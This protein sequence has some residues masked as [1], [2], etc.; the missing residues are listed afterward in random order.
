MSSGHNPFIINSKNPEHSRVVKRNSSEKRFRSLGFL[1]IMIS[2]SF[3]GFLLFT[4]FSKGITG[5]ITTKIQLELPI[6]AEIDKYEGD[7]IEEIYAKLNYRKIVNQALMKIFP[8]AQTRREKFDLYSMLSRTAYIQAE[9]LV[10][11]DYK[12]SGIIRNV[13][14][15]LTAASEVDMLNKGK[16]RTDVPENKRNISDNQI[17]YVK[18]LEKI[19]A[20]ES[21]F[22]KAFFTKGDSREAESAGILGSITGSL[23]VIFICM[24]AALP[25]GIA[26][27]IYLE[28]FAPASRLKTV[29][30][31]AINNLAAIPSIVYG[32]LGLAVFLNWFGMP[33]SSAMAG[34]LTLGL[35]VLPVIII[36]TRNALAAVPPSIRDAARGLGAS[37]MQ[38][39]FHHVLPLSMPGIMTGS[40]L[41]L[42]RALGETA[43]LLMIGMVAFIKDVPQDVM[44]PATALPVQ[45]YI[46]S[47]LPEMG[48]AEKTSAAIIVL[49]LFLVAANA[50]AVFL[51]KKFEYKW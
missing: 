15:W 18:K 7:N 25:L 51:R 3:L 35:L 37:K 8:D 1:A 14:V 11:Q 10:I 40:I 27:A 17:E 22:N 33:R 32:L 16:V 43:P 48:F 38:V 28:E 36:A 50:L 6:E 2:I 26:A 31:I 19:N 9:N 42:A 4:I 41:S 12:E 5:F 47:D 39:V 46:W 21:F 34:G 29:V 44:D 49:L 13:N 30:E 23:F 24:V 45:V 20:I